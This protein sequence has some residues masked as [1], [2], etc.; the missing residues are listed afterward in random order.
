MKKIKLKQK[1]IILFG[2]SAIILLV[3][4]FLIYMLF[5][6]LVLRAV[7]NYYEENDKEIFISNNEIVKSDSFE[8]ESDILDLGIN[9]AKVAVFYKGE[10]YRNTSQVTITDFFYLERTGLISWEVKKYESS[11]V[12]YYEQEGYTLDDAYEAM[13]KNVKAGEVTHGLTPDQ[14]RELLTGSEGTLN[15]N[16]NDLVDYIQTANQERTIEVLAGEKYGTNYL[17]DTSTN[18]KLGIENV[19][20]GVFSTDGK[21]LVYTT[22]EFI[23]PLGELIPNADIWVYDFENEP[24]KIFEISDKPNDVVLYSNGKV[25]VYG[26][27]NLIGL[28]DID[29]T[30]QK[31]LLDFTA[32]DTSSQFFVLPELEDQ[33]DGTLRISVPSENYSEDM[34]MVLYSLE[35][36]IKKLIEL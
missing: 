16:P 3:I 1:R 30:G 26:T 8:Y 2:V 14:E 10:N 20:R 11:Y 34:E 15:T 32:V 33:G 24:K 21:Y 36:S 31:E 35:I 5:N 6:S 28:M 27:K 12:P 25:I 22:G 7:A 4:S 29:G 23:E 17:L 9:S 19:V 18:E 13:K